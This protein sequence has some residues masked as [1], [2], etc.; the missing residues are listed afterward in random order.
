MCVGVSGCAGVAV[1]MGLGARAHVLSWSH[2]L[3]S[4]L[5][6]LGGGSK[7]QMNLGQEARALPGEPRGELAVWSKKEC[8][9]SQ[10]AGA[11]R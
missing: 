1:V 11:G 5:G 6:R 3:E 7:L 4:L 9:L 2:S 10:G 8:I